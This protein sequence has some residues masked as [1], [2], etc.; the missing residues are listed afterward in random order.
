M[1]IDTEPPEPP[2][3]ETE[4]GEEHISEED[5][6][7]KRVLVDIIDQ[8]EIMRDFDSDSEEDAI[9]QQI[10]NM[11]LF[12]KKDKKFDPKNF[13]EEEL[14][15]IGKA[16]VQERFDEL[17]REI[18]DRMKNPKKPQMERLVEKDFDSRVNEL[19]NFD[20]GGE[21]NLNKLDDT[22]V[23]LYAVKGINTGDGQEFDIDN[24]FSTNQQQ[25]TIPPAVGLDAIMIDTASVDQQKR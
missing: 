11:N 6:P 19:E 1:Q 9:T 7:E 2:Q 20:D 22:E 15:D 4:L 10:L 5:K 18:M 21:V 12:Y 3:K 14:M 24:F 23:T 8:E 13:T 25:V 17:G 16:V